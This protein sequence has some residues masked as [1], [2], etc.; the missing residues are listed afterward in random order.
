MGSFLLCGARAW[1]GARLSATIMKMRIR[2]TSREATKKLGRLVASRIL[3]MRRR[4]VARKGAVV[5]ALRGD[6]GGGKTTF[7]QGLA[8]GLGIRI[9][10]RSPT[11]IL[12]QIFSFGR[13]EKSERRMVHIDAYRFRRAEDARP[14]GLQEIFKDPNAVVVIEWAEKIR[15]FLPKKTIWIR[16][17]H[18]AKQVRDI[19]VPA[20]LHMPRAGRA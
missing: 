16:F 2:T 5:L 1:S 11:F 10:P 6:L 12:M 3:K 14:L 13:R 9:A 15:K 7:V 17:S 4:P 8:R 18:R 19:T 20:T